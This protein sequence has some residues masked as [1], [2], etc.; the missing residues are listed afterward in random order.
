MS[1]EIEQRLAATSQAARAYDLCQQQHAQLSESEQAAAADL[2]T[3]RQ[4]CADDE[5]DVERLE[6]V[7]LTRVLAALHGSRED[8]LAR[9]KAEADAAR[10][11]V[12]QAQ[13]RLDAARTE[14]TSL[15]DRQARL[16]GAP[17]AYADALAA[18]EEYLTHSADPRGARLLALADE[19]GRMTAELSELRRS[20]DD[21]ATAARALAEVQDRL[22]TAANWSTFDTYLDHGMIAN[23]IKHDRID[24]AAQSAQVADQRL[25]ALR[26]DLS[27]LGGVEPAAPRLEISSGFRFADIFFNNIFTDLA[28]G[29]QIS[30]AQDTVDQSVQQ[31]G[32]LQD[33]LR[34]QMAKVSGQLDGI[35]AERRQ[36]L[37]Q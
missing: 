24:Q 11:R 8:K 13:Q 7:S 33:R 5:K 22:G 30:D 9:Q 28:V 26:T 1:D 14:L 16:A 23:S 15:Q 10:Y 3:A 21:A 34:D 32:A 35:D 2:D 20:H 4:Q 36:L 27:E 25:A 18:K 29:R 17:Q 19:R 12:T 37:T 31:V 6:H